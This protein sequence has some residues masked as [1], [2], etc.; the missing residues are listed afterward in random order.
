MS[1]EEG[2]CVM[3]K[4]NRLIKINL[5]ISP[6]ADPLSE[7]ITSVQ[8]LKTRTFLTNNLANHDIDLFT[9][10]DTLTSNATDVAYGGLHTMPIR[11]SDIAK[12][13]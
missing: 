13:R 6:T 1:E 12:D 4:T 5:L 2:L 9:T 10:R 3:A 8:Q 7:K 11:A